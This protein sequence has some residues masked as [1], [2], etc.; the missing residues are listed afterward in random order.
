M[1]RSI[2]KY[3]L[4]VTDEQILEIPGGAKILS[5]ELQH[6]VPCLWALVHPKNKKKKR[7]VQIFGTGNPIPDADLGEYVSTFQSMGGNLVW[8]VFIMSEKAH[9]SH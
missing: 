3:P 6:G 8:H 2:W 5:V 9:L 1:P 7:V 4:K